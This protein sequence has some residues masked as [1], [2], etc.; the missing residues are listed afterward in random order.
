[1]QTCQTKE[2]IQCSGCEHNI[3][4]DEP[5]LSDLPGDLPEE[6]SRAAFRHFHISCRECNT[7]SSCYQAFAARQTRFSAQSATVCAGC[8][9]EIRVGEDTIRDT[10]WVK[11]MADN[12]EE[13]ADMG[14]KFVGVGKAAKNAGRPMSFS[15]FA[16]P[17]EAQ[18]LHRRTGKRPRNTN[19][20][21]GA[22][23]LPQ[24]RPPF[25]SQHG[26]ASRPRVPTGQRMP[27]TFNLSGTRRARR[28]YPTMSCGKTTRAT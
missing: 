2:P 13:Y 8:D 6:L 16:L 4:V 11:T 24:F 20:R 15:E 28:S 9:H 18:V 17:P 22:G 23:I 10:V 19:R 26:A 12:G 27:A 7:E 21:G 14:G 1:M 25:G 3:S 5:F